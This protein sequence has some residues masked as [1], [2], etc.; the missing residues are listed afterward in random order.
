[1]FTYINYQFNL[2]VQIDNHYSIHQTVNN[3]NYLTKKLLNILVLDCLRSNC[4]NMSI[5]ID[6]HSIALLFTNFQN[7]L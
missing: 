7:D 1:M 3:Q 2:N 5:E 4:L 6:N